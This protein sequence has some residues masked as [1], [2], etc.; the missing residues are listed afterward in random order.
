MISSELFDL[1]EACWILS[2]VEIM[3]VAW[4][5]LLAYEHNFIPVRRFLSVFRRP[6]CEIAV[7]VAIVFGFVRTGATKST[8]VLDRTGGL[9]DVARGE[10]EVQREEVHLR[11]ADPDEGPTNLVFTAYSVTPSNEVFAADWPESILPYGSRI[12]LHERQFSLT[13]AWCPV[14]E[15][16]VGLGQTNLCDTL[17]LTNGHPPV[18]FKALYGD[19]IVI[20][21]PD[22]P[23]IVNSATGRRL[24]VSTTADPVSVS[25]ERSLRP[26]EF[27]PYDPGFAA[28]PFAHVEGLAYDSTNETVATVGPGSF[29]LATGDEL[30]V[31]APSMTVSNVM[32]VSCAS[33]A[34]PAQ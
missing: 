15:Y 19:S 3:L 16:I 25:V 21:F 6:I 17:A 4:L 13:N 14:R 9:W 24:S 26:P 22:L 7:L 29:E 23:T 33:V 20:T 1:R 32:G 5:A 12:E 18:A 31:L 30:V 8:N 11:D 28:D 27:T 34:W 2:T 10:A